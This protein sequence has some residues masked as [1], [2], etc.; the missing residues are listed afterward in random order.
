MAYLWFMGVAEVVLCN[1]KAPLH[2]SV[3]VC[4]IEPRHAVQLPVQTAVVHS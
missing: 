2:T 3:C 1:Q 4:V